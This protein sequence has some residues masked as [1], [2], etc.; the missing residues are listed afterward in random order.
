MRLILLVSLTMVAFAANSILNRL[1]V[2]GGQI[3]ALSFAAIRLVA[4]AVAL[5]ALV[6]LQRRALPLVGPNRWAGVLSLT[7][8]MI[9]FSLAYLQ[10]DTGVGALI[11]FGGVQVTMFAGAVLERQ[12]ISAS[13]WIGAGLALAGLAWLLW[14][15]GAGAPSIPHAALMAAAAVGWGIYSLAGRS[16]GPPL[17]ATAANFVLAAPFGIAVWAFAAVAGQ[18]VSA[19]PSGIALA[20]ISGVVTSG[21]GYALWYSLLPALPT[22]AA[23]LVQLSV[24]VIA[25]AGGV[26]LLAEPVTV[27]LVLS[28]LLVLGGIGIGV[29]GARASGEA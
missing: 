15:A 23:A 3:D 29:L 26:A 24:P 16:A 8:Y 18:A 20:I 28:S 22:T 5:A 25:A 2:A 12:P 4:G 13:R 6:A 10:L 21:F 17:Q 1:A 14:P 27:R 9:G 7:L 19:G 11:L